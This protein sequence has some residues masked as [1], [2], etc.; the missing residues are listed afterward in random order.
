MNVKLNGRTGSRQRQVFAV[1]RP[2]ARVI[3]CIIVEAAKPFPPFIIGPDPFLESFLDA[4]LFFPCGLGGLRVDDGFLVHIIINGGRFEIERFLDEFEA[5]ITVR[6][7]IGRVRGRAFRLP[8]AGDVPRAERVDV[9]DLN[10]RRNAEQSVDEMLHVRWR[11]PGRAKPHVVNQVWLSYTRNFGGREFG[12]DIAG[13]ILV[14]CFPLLGLRMEKNHPFQV[15]QKIFGWTRKQRGHVFQIHPAFFI[16]RNEQR[17]FGRTDRFNRLLVVNRPFAEDGRFDR[18]FGFLVVVFQRE[19]QRQ[20]RVAVKSPLVDRD[21]D[22]A[23][24]GNEAVVGMI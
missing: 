7:P 22:R 3:E 11:Q 4:L 14:F 15:G 9:A 13:K 2:N 16:Q 12:P 5:G 23:E 6:P 24:T 1:E 8:I 18:H 19:Q 17:F 10:P 20:I 21:I